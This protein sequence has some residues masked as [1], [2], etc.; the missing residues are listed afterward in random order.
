MPEWDSEN[1]YTILILSDRNNLL[2]SQLYIKERYIA[3]MNSLRHSTCSLVTFGILLL[4]GI[5]GSASAA[6]SLTL[7][8]AIYEAC[9]NSD[10]VKMMKESVVKAGLVVRE[11]KSAAFPKVATSATVNRNNPIVNE[12]DDEGS[13][14]T[15]PH[16]PL[17][18][19]EFGSMI[20]SMIGSFATPKPSTIYNVSLSVTQPIYT[21]GKIE[22]AMKVARSYNN[23]AK[24]SYKRNLQTLQLTALDMY[25]RT[26]IAHA[27]AA[28]SRKTLERKKE[29]F[30]FIENN[31]SMGSGEKA[32]LM[33]VKADAYS[34]S[35]SLIVAEREAQTARMYLNAFL[36]RPLD[37]TW[38]ID[39]S[40]VPLVLEAAVEVPAEGMISEAIEKRDDIQSI[41]YLV[42]SNQK[43]ANI[44]RSM[45][46]PSIFANGSLGFNQIDSKGIMAQEGAAEWKAGVTISWTL[47]DGYENSSKA[48]QLRSDANKLEVAESGLKKA[49]EIEIKSAVIECSAADSALYASQQMHGAASEA[50]ELI[51]SNY[52]Q[53]SG[54]L[55]DL[56]R[57]DEQL[58]LAEL[59]LVNARYRQ[60]R[61]KAAL[62]IALGR[63]IVPVK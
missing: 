59:A 45:Y 11:N 43:G 16:T 33:M 52:R 10:S 21:F 34:Q 12:D 30:A 25:Y 39:T 23:S 35:A 26:L 19:D 56:Q 17:Y 48:L 41:K 14:P 46:Y 27:N 20:G 47:F 9:T 5:S 24:S 29:L 51:N 50:Y 28:I 58:Q 42:E 3:I 53:G 49:V 38:E 2:H 32:Q 60:I 40:S 57:V 31:F 63:D 8:Q 61:S 22:N 54:S 18:A 4:A 13:Q 55:T 62:L 15:P 44:Y 6:P 36:G 7:E 1:N 37:D